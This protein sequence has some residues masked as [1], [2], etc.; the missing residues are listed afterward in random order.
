MSD[1]GPGVTNPMLYDPVPE[2]SQQTSK[3]MQFV[4]AIGGK[5]D[6]DFFWGEGH[7]R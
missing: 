3:T 2:G 5:C 7:Y 1:N 6:L 4:A